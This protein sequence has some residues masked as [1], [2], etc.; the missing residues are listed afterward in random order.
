MRVGN[1]AALHKQHDVFGEM[2]LAL[3][4]LFLDARFRDQ[5]TPPV[6]DLVTRLA[7]K[8]VLVAGQPDAGIWEYRS[9]WRPQTFS[10]LMC[11]AAAD[12]MSRIALQHRPEA[13]EEFAMAANRIRAE[14]LQRAVDPARGCLVADYGGTEVDAALLQAVTLHFLPAEDP[15]LHAT[16]DAIRA[17]LECHGWLKRYRTDDGFGVPVVAFMLCTFWLVEA[18]A[19]LGRIDEARALMTACEQS[20]PRWVSSAKTSSRSRARCGAISRKPIR[21]S[22]S[23]T[24]P[25][26]RRLVGQRL[27]LEADSPLRTLDSWRVRAKGICCRRCRALDCHS[28]WGLAIT[29]EALTMPQSRC[30]SMAI[31]SVRSAPRPFPSSSDC[32]RGGSRACDSCFD[33]SL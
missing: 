21:T 15:R 2:V 25:S 16:V 7:R 12:R 14:L 8:A 33:T 30:F 3:T 10:S 23:S 18:L 6:L 28:R 19:R 17:D 20:S 4:P 26:R 11:W 29:Y 27:A 24:Q 5:V 1:G 13:V 31:S 9:E 32:K 22:V